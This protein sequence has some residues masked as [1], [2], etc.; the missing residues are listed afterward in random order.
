MGTMTELPAPPH[1]AAAERAVLGACLNSIHAYREAAELLS[2]E[3]WYL[4]QHL[5]L[6]QLIRR[7]AATGAKPDPIAVNS[8]LATADADTRRLVDGHLLAKLFGGIMTAANVAH[9]AQQVAEAGVRRRLIQAAQGVM[10]RAAELE[11][12]SEAAEWAVTEMALARDTRQGPDATDVDVHDLLGEHLSQ[13]WV[14]EG[15]LAQG[16]RLVLTASEGLGKSTLLRQIAV[17][18]AAGIHPFHNTPMDPVRVLVVDCENGRKLSRDRYRP[19]VVQAE[20]MGCPVEDRLRIDIRP[21][22]LN[23]LTAGDASLLL[24]MVER[25]QPDL[26]LIGPIY[27]LHEDDPNDEK[28]ARKIAAVLDR[29]R[30][31]SGC[32]LITEAHT[33]H[34]DGP[35]GHMLRP[36]GSSL[37]KRWPEFGYCLK[38]AAESDM[39]ARLCKLVAWRGPRDERDWPLGLKAGG[40]W[41]WTPVLPQAMRFTS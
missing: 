6:W 27:R 41:P 10:Q 23:L 22:G 30:A 11:D 38:L 1:D 2:D 25:V 7:V 29:A 8:A 18:A 28:A 40:D 13:E 26:M 3:D 20:R 21:S 24:R 16:D 35:G 37:W 34:S 19:L 33:P 32:A 36:F 4:P 31:A 12:V 17:T 9:Y 14:I 5:A 15:L 39:N